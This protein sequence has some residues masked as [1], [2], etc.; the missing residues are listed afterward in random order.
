MNATRKPLMAGNWK[1]YKTGAEAEAYLQALS[2]LLKGKPAADLPDIVVC[3]PFT[4]LDAANRTLNDGSPIA[5]GAQNMASQP[6]GAFTGEVS[7][8]MLQAVNVRYVII[9]HSERREYFNE[10]DESV[11]AKVKAA[12]AN[13]LVPIVCVGESLAQRESGQTDEWVSA[14]V[15]AALAGI[16]SEE[17]TRLVMAYEPIWAIGTG[18]VCEADEANRVIDLIRQV[19]EAPGMRILYGGS[20]KPDNVTGLMAQPEIDGGLVGGAS[21]EPESMMRLIEAAMPVNV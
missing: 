2:G 9:G 11:N 8:R 5:L 17:R 6:E 15:R 12:L 19:A 4:A 20:M 21:L 1:M 10:T 14:Q 7:V 13:N 3:A 16:S 18:K